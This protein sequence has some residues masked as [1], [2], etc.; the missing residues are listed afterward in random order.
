M[1][2]VVTVGL[3]FSYADTGAQIVSRFE[4][5]PGQHQDLLSQLE[6]NHEWKEAYDLELTGTGISAERVSFDVGRAAVLDVTGQ[7]ALLI[8]ITTK[9]FIRLPSLPPGASTILADEGEVFLYA[10]GVYRFDEDKETW[11]M[12]A[13][14]PN[15]PGNVSQLRLFDHNFYVLSDAGIYKLPAV[16]GK[17]RDVHTWLDENE[18]LAG[19][20]LDLYLDGYLYV[21]TDAGIQRYLRGA[22]TRWQ[23]EAT[24]GAPLYLD[25][26][27]REQIIVL[28]PTQAALLY[29]DTRGQVTETRQ[30]N[31][32]TGARFIG[33]QAADDTIFTLI[34]QKI[35]QF[36]PAQITN[37]N[38]QTIS[39]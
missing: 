34:G 15:I 19:R 24:A 31:L 26:D 21:S 6:K 20:P 37:E 18:T 33:Y 3:A 2:T 4:T 1:V 39:D 10:H 12:L 14:D 9:N 13:A 27:G 22:A 36:V 8:D 29:A 5:V 32:L 7:Q 11:I 30:D 38:G 28:A 16:D 25:G 17:Y 35:Y 23:L